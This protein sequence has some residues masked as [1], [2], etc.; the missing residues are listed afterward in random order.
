MVF[1]RRILTVLKSHFM[2]LMLDRPDIWD[3]WQVPQGW[4]HVRGSGRGQTMPSRS[5]GKQW[6]LGYY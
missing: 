2:I 4:K 6:V 3:E 5:E 1:H